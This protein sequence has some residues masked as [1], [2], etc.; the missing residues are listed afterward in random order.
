MAGLHPTQSGS[1][2]QEDRPDDAHGVSLSSPSSAS[3]PASASFAPPSPEVMTS[4]ANRDYVVLASHMRRMAMQLDKVRKILALIERES[5]R[6]PRCLW[7]GE[8]RSYYLAP[9]QVLFEKACF[10]EHGVENLTE[11]LMRCHDLL[12]SRPSDPVLD[13]AL[14]MLRDARLVCRQMR[15]V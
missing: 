4:P 15:R 1:L 6:Q 5:F 8:I 3:S 10:A 14:A 9:R 11:M 7:G 2:F 13:I 12:A